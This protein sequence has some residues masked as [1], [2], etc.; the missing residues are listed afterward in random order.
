MTPFNQR[1]RE[2]RESNN[3]S[4]Q[5]LAEIVGVSKSTIGMY[6]QGRREPSYEVEEALADYFNVD[7]DYLRGRTDKTTTIYPMRDTKPQRRFLMDRIAKADDKKLD[8]IKKLME[9]IEDE[10]ADNW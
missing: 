10:E 4:Q 9:L 8:K 2:L 1:L 5:Q 3:L 7:L 6:E